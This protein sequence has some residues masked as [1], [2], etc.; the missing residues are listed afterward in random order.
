MKL[1][2]EQ[3]LGVAAPENYLELKERNMS[4]MISTKLLLSIEDAMTYEGAIRGAGNWL[5]KEKRALVYIGIPNPSNAQTASRYN[6]D[7][8]NGTNAPTEYGQRVEYLID[9]FYSDN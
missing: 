5:G 4:Q 1:A 6:N 8:W 3:I 9:E 7:S 2:D